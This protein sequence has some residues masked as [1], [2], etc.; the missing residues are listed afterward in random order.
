MRAYPDN[1]ADL[2]N[3]PDHGVVASVKAMWLNAQICG[4]HARAE[5]EADRAAGIPLLGLPARHS[6]EIYDLVDGVP[7]FEVCDWRTRRAHCV[8]F[9]C[10]SQDIELL[11]AR[12]IVAPCAGPCYWCESARDPSRH[13]KG[14]QAAAQKLADVVLRGIPVQQPALTVA[15]DFGPLFGGAR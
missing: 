12:A 11:L 7:V 6:H 2:L 10:G 8:C 1:W 4:P 3:H 5:I 13:A 14:I 9:R 15:I